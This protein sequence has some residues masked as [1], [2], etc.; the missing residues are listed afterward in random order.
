MGDRWRSVLTLMPSLTYDESSSAYF[1]ID[2]L[3][4]HLALLT[5][6]RWRP[7]PGRARCWW[8]RS[9]YLAAPFWAWVDARDEATRAALG[10]FA[11]NYV[12]S[13]AKGPIPGTG[14]DAIRLPAGAQPYPFQ[15]AGV[16]RIMLRK[17]VMIAD[18]MGLGKSLQALA[19]I[20]LL[21]PKR[22][23]IGCPA[24]AEEH[25]A[26]QCEQWLVDP[27]S[28]TI[29]GRGKKGSPDVG[30]SILPYSRG[31]RYLEQILRGAPIDYLIM[32]EVHHLKSEGARRTGIWF[33]K[34]ALAQAAER[35]VAIT[36]TPI[37]NHAGEVYGVL[38]A[39]APDT[40]GAMGREAFK[41]SYCSTFRGTAKVARK[42][43]GESTVQF[44]KNETRHEA[45]LNAEMR[46]SGVMVRRLKDDVLPQLPPCH[47]FLVHLTPTQEID[48]LVREEASLFDMLQ[49]K[50]LTSQELI[51]LQGHIA[52]VR[53]RLGVLKA[54]KISDFIKSLY[55]GGETHVVVFMLHTAAIE[56]IRAAFDDTRVTVR[57]LS[58]AMTPTERQA[59]ALLFQRRVGLELVIGQVVAAGEIITLT[60]ARYVVSGE[61][62]WT[63]SR[64][65]QAT[66]RVHR[67]SQTRQVENPI[68]TF[69]HA[70]EERVI[71]ANAAKEISANRVLNEN[72]QKM[73]T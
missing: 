49:T 17:R 53:A 55:E 56:V 9:P 63:P 40:A 20:N 30:V 10:P 68:V 13:F 72:L 26:S 14:I 35:V 18:Q 16:Q 43:G 4:E 21:R 29:L 38:A 62:D 71:R 3:D 66:D 8:T 25:W 27:R 44:E 39:L 70:V 11:W 59:Q 61:L 31:H 36:G 60:A 2:A 33:G 23:I 22:I 7:H 64:N 1:V 67:I 42:S 45:A 46:A 19:A 52:N 54:P 48:D 12:T 58:G 5:D 32:D 50:L 47:S 73:I 34:E 51:S 28:I 37:P 57:V 15:I 6:L 69:P 65:A 41:D 24:A